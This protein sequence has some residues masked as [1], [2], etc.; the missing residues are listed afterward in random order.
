VSVR[1]RFDGRQV[2]A[3]AVTAG[4]LLGISL[5]ARPALQRAGLA[6]FQDPGPRTVLERRLGSHAPRGS[7]VV[8][9]LCEA[10]DNGGFVPDREA[11]A[12]RGVR[13]EA[14]GGGGGTS[15]HATSSA[16]SIVAIAPSVSAIL[17]ASSQWF[18]DDFLRSG[19]N[20][21]PRSLPPQIGVLCFPWVGSAGAPDDEVLR[22]LDLVLANGQGVAIAGQRPGSRLLASSYNT[23]AAG[24]EGSQSRGTDAN[25]DG[26]GR[27]KPELVGPSSASWVTA[28]VA[29]AAAVLLD[30]ANT[31]P[32]LAANPAARRNETIKA[33]LLTGAIRSAAWSN[34]PER[35]TD[36]LVDA[37]AVPLDRNDGAGRLDV[38]RAHLV[39]TG[40]VAA[41]SSTSPPLVEA[42]GWSLVPVETA[43]EW[44]WQVDLPQ[45]GGELAIVACW[46]RTFRPGSL[47]WS[48][49]DFD[50]SIRR[51]GDARSE[52]TADLP[53]AGDGDAPPPTFAASGNLASRSRVDNVEM[54]L[55]REVA[56]G[57]YAFT[58]AR[59]DGE[60]V[61]VAVAWLASGPYRAA[62]AG[63]E[64]PASPR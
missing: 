39:L 56:P 64:R 6:A 1:V 29:G 55:L 3:A 36:R 60:P 41:A 49:A 58:L 16:R 46:N 51:V 53:T 22:R 62:G 5:L 54:I 27:C 59:V 9:L 20:E 47:E 38:N 7:G 34:L 14:L 63:V 52:R 40:E 4:V 15:G 24:N 18:L 50:L 2:A 48:L 37:T 10:P 57:R 30:A 12:L 13:I 35:A 61:P 25:L 8:V 17:A 42:R 21:P 28:E 43:A 31:L 45:G 44:T 32:S 26:P 11:G 19:R 23:I 33:A